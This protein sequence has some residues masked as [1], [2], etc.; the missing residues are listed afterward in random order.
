MARVKVYKAK[1]HNILT[2]QLVISRRMAI[3]DGAKTMRGEILQDTEV[4]ID[5][6]QLENGE[7]WTPI[8]FTP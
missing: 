1:T 4:E 2:D 3:Q 8:D 6:S 5:E 7:Q